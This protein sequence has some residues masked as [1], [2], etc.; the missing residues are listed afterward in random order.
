[1]ARLKE[2]GD[3]N[4]FLSSRVK[5][6]EKE[7]ESCNSY[8]DSLYSELHEK[9][10]PSDELHAELEKREEEWLELESRY[11]A[12]I[13]QLQAELNAQSK[14][15]SM[16]MYLVVMKE[17]RRH[18]IDSAEK[19]L[20]I[21]ELTSMVGDL[22]DEIERIKRSPPKPALKSISSLHNKVRPRQVSPTYQQHS[23]FGDAASKENQEPA[24]TKN[25]N[26]NSS[27]SA[28]VTIAAI[29]SSLEAR[30]GLRAR[31]VANTNESRD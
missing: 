20:K 17:S 25:R 30:K 4:A 18:K 19:Q 14:K 16:E 8:I 22:R 6:L 1:M 10:S 5:E 24:T 27:K 7:L 23:S 28:R 13:E 26:E 15:V 12:T 11:N 29:K 9:S 31:R 21:D 2:T 3:E